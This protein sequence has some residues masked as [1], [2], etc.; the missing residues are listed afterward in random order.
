MY[1]ELN[2][3]LGSNFIGL[4]AAPEPNI[5]LHDINVVVIVKNVSSKVRQEVIDIARQVEEDLGT[6]PIISSITLE[7]G[8]LLINEF[9]GWFYG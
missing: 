2:E 9:K 1:Q 3:R 6:S 4:V 8:D 5:T 7:R